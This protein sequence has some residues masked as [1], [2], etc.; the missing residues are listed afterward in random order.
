MR[1]RKCFPYYYDNLIYWYYHKL[2]RWGKKNGIA[3]LKTET[4]KEYVKKVIEHITKEDRNFIY[5]GENYD[6]S[7]LIRKL[8]KDYQA[9]F[10]GSEIGKFEKTEYKL[11]LNKLKGIRL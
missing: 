5:K 2:L 4:S 10:F 6:L 3:R 7:E 8:N 1:W 11:L 9:A